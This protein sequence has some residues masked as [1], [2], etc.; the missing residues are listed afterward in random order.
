MTHQALARPRFRLG[1]Q[2][3]WH[4]T[5]ADTAQ[6]PRIALIHGLL[7]GRHMQRHMLQQV[8][9]WGYADSTLFANHTAAQP[10]ADWLARA[11]AHGRPVVLIGYSQG[12]FLAVQVARRLAKKGI[13]VDLLVTIAAGGLGRVYPAQ[14]GVEPRQIPANVHRVINAF[15]AADR[16]GGDRNWQVNF[17]Q[18][19]HWQTHI[20]NIGFSAQHAIDHIALVRCG[21]AEREHPVVKTQLFDHIQQALNEL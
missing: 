15:S 19:T 6:G 20:D 12:G 13:A 3:S 10:I 21:P 4:A 17:A 1:W 7:A 2:P 9:D 18:P 14:W 11:V 16:L 8:R 5:S